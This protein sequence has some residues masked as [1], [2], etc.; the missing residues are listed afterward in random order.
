LYRSSFHI[1]TKEESLEETHKPIH[2]RSPILR[3]MIWCAAAFCYTSEQWRLKRPFLTRT[4]A[5]LSIV[6]LAL[7]TILISSAKIP[8]LHTH[9][10]ASGLSKA[11]VVA[12][13]TSSPAQVTLE[14]TFLL[15][16][17]SWPPPSTTRAVSRIPDLHTIIPKRPQVPVVRK[18][19][20][21]HVVQQGETLFSVAS[22]FGLSLTTVVWSN[23]EAFQ[24]VPWLVRAGTKLFILP[25]NGV[26][27]TTRSGETAESIATSYGIDP[28]DL[29]NEW[30]DLG[31]EEQPHEGQR[32]VVPGGQ[33]EPLGWERLS[34]Y[35]AP[36]LA[37]YRYEV[38]DGE[39]AIGPGG[40]GWFTYPTGKSEVSGWVF[41]DP[42]RRI[43]IGIDY[44]CKLDDPIYAADNGVVTWAGRNGTYGIMVE[45]NHGSD[46]VT[47]YGHFS[48][49]AVECGQPVYQGDLIGYCGNTGW[50]SGPHLHFEIRQ[51]NVP[52]DPETYLPPLGS[53]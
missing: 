10:S 43:H 12:Q 37:T 40:H 24:D 19:V 49:L 31:R 50:S 9:V 17:D 25:V 51:D 16:H 1:S 30:N 32:L 15:T 11:D 46:F 18:A 8:E 42:R 48:S 5:H 2:L 13:I 22:R 26:Y 7:A 29:Y 45:I 14:P 53:D 20:V 21:T 28:A 35:P 33:G 4:T 38:C 36:E 6:V 52:Q 23:P 44:R 39:E 3:A 47:R 41:H 27:H 34:K